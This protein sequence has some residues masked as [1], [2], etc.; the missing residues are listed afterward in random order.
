MTLAFPPAGWSPRGW[1]GAKD[2]AKQRNFTPSEVF[3]T[4][5]GLGLWLCFIIGSVAGLMAIGIASNVGQEVIK[6]D[7]ATATA[8]VSVFAIFNG[9]GRPI[10]G[11][12]TDKI[13][14][15][16]AAI[17]SLALVLIAS[18][19]M[20]AFAGEGSTFVYVVCFCAFWMG[21]GS[22]LAIAP[23]ST[24]TYFG[25]KN[26]APNYGWL[27]SAYGI[28]AIIAGLVAGNAKDMFGSYMYAFYV[29]GGLAALGIILAKTMMKSPQNNDA[30]LQDDKNKTL[31]RAA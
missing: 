11:W 27:F 7:A 20:I 16:N 3:A 6:L 14:P 30:A 12:L 9:G 28:G 8:L 1:Q 4:K 2:A 26:Y 23:T 17:L 19:S 10:F 31:R 25:A 15:A 21:L 18:A 22:W 29:S 13:G 5:A 24:L